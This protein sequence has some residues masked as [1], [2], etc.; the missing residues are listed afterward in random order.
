MSILERFHS[1]VEIHG[2]E[3]KRRFSVRQIGIFGSCARGD[4]SSASDVDILVSLDMKTFDNYMELKFF[5]EEKF[6]RDVDL[7]ID[8][9]IKPSLKKR[10]MEE[11]RYAA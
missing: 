11:V 6:G 5:L 9:S 8:E 3:M 4:D 2:E 1:I 7:V 10:I